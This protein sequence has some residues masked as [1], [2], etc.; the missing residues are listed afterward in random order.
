MDESRAGD[1]LTLYLPVRSTL[2]SRGRG[3]Y[4]WSRNA[5]GCYA[6]RSRRSWPWRHG[7]TARVERG[8]APDQVIADI[9]GP[10]GGSPAAF[11]L[12]AVDVLISHPAEDHDGGRC[13]PWLAR[14][15]SLDRSRQIH[16]TMPEMDL[17]GWRCDR[18]E[19]ARR[20]GPLSA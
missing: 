14:L 6:I 20:R 12:V 15:L 5:E 2:L 18:P 11:L 7:L 17:L 9:L 4:Y 8:D 13:V 16:D 19:G 3:S 1:G 10:G